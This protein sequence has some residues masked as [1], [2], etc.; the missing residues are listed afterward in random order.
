M[1]DTDGV[2]CCA[3]GAGALCGCCRSD[4]AF[5]EKIEGAGAGVV[6]KAPGKD[7]CGVDG[8]RPEVAIV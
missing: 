8:G 2:V 3:P 4:C 6:R 5:W 7:R 1:A